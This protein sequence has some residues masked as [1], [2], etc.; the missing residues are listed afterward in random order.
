MERAETA[1]GR[2]GRAHAR[3]IDPDPLIPG[4]KT[5]RAQ[6]AIERI[7]IAG[8]AGID[9]ISWEPFQ[10]AML[11]DTSRLSLFRKSRQ[12]AWS[13]TAAAEAWI[14][15]CVNGASSIFVSINLDEAK[16]KIRY[17][18]A[19]YEHT[20]DI[21]KPEIVRDNDLSIEFRGGVSLVSLPSR[22]PR[23]KARRN[24][25]LDEFAHVAK[26]REIYKGALPVISKGGRLRMGS[27]PMGARGLFWEIDTQS[28]QSYPG[29]RRFSVPWW[30]VRAFCSDIEEARRLAPN[31]LT[32]ERVSI[33]GTDAIR[34]LYENAV[35]ED[36]QQEYECIYVYEVASWITWDEIARNE[37]SELVC[38]ERTF[39]SRS[40]G[41]ALQLI[42]EARRLCEEGVFEPALGAGIDIGR[43]RN[44]TELYIGARTTTGAMPLRVAITL[45]G[46]EFED[47][48]TVF[49]RALDVLPI[50][51]LLIDRN[52]LGM[53]LAESLE[54]AYP[55][56]AQGFN[57][58]NET[59]KLLATDTK[60]FMQRSAVPIPKSRE[61][62]Y[63]IHSIRRKVSS[64][65]LFIFDTDANEKHHADKFWALG[66]MLHAIGG[67][68]SLAGSVSAVTA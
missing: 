45:D 63:Q 28:M 19:L 4:V 23:G 37:S 14:D 54:R 53:Q 11:N 34:M 18:R 26:D 46:V 64:S 35:L 60:L 20:Y 21:D 58:T 44:T 2:G 22:P 33:F 66:L 43:T 12:V 38:L 41:E 9:G 57:F 31:M 47:Q 30:E 56:K 16:E 52:G 40:V 25:Y 29:Y 62:A 67:R 48:Y 61:L 17:A 7:D 27:S 39:N 51:T 36:F 32:D 24:V 55:A 1:A 59:K 50:H 5:F 68:R 15:A 6:F 8:A 65:G 42:E 3:T 13:F 10:I 49:A